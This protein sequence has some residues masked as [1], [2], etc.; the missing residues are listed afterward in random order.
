MQKGQEVKVISEDIR[1]PKGTICVVEEVVNDSYDK[2][3]Y[4]RN[5]ESQYC[6]WA[7]SKDLQVL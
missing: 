4:I 7:S 1:L 2:P 6:C 3:Y 5:I